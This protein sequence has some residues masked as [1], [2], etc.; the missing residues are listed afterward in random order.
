MR[1]APRRSDYVADFCSR[2]HRRFIEHLL[3]DDPLHIA[4]ERPS[5]SLWHAIKMSAGG[6][7][8]YFSRSVDILRK[9]SARG[10]LPADDKPHC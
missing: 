5:S 3:A 7:K 4:E 8:G 6:L 1:L 10:E 9:N 2:G